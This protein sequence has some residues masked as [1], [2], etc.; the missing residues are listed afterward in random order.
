MKIAYILTTF[1][2]RSETFA[3][4][5]IKGLRELGLDITVLAA[6]EQHCSPI[7]TNELKKTLYKP[8]LLSWDAVSS[9]GYIIIKYPFALARLTYLILKLVKSSPREAMCLIANLHTIIFFSKHLDRNNISH[10]H[11][12]FLSWPACIGLA[13]ATIINRTFSI[14]A[15]AR[16]IFVEHGAIRLKAKHAGFIVSCTQQ[17]LR[18]LQAN[19][20]AKYH[21]KLYL[22][23]HGI[24]APYTGCDCHG[25]NIS[26]SRIDD[27]IIAVGRLV[28]KKGFINLLKALALVVKQKPSCKLMIV[29]DGPERKRLTELVLEQG[30]GD[31]VQFLGWL[32]INETQRFIRRA[33]IVTVPSIIADDGDRDGVPNV[34]LEAFVGKVPVIASA[35]ESISEIVKDEETGLLVRP[36]NISEL[37]LT[38][39]RLLDDKNLRRRLSQKAYEMIKQHFNSSDNIKQLSELFMGIS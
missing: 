11:A 33:A 34:I 30:I 12:Y 24:K 28:Q 18:Q 16:D 10:I 6:T 8:P 36:G 25:N 14:A 38:I 23:R 3:A 22:N 7:D 27:L 37:A 31:Y 35:L 5:E 9:L 26:E 17:G 13:V 4:R 29:G 2:C 19:L 15:H 39:Q 1:P 21:N 32:N 20:P